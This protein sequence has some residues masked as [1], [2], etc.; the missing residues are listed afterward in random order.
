MFITLRCA[1]GGVKD[2]FSSLFLALARRGPVFKGL[3]PV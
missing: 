1:R 2:W 3:L